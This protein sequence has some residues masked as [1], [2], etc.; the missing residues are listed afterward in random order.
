MVLPLRGEEEGT[1]RGWR[2]GRGCS[3]GPHWIHHLTLQRWVWEDC[4]K[5]GDLELEL[6]YMSWGTEERGIKRASENKFIRAQT[7]F[8]STED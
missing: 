3:S 4:L 2:G 7:L 1:H 6:W 8:T 5:S